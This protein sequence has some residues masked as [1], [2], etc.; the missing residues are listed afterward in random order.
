MNKP[1]LIREIWEQPTWHFW[2]DEQEYFIFVSTDDL[3]ESPRKIHLCKPKKQ[4]DVY[5]PEYLISKM[6]WQIKEHEDLKTGIE[7]LFLP[8]V[9]EYLASLDGGDSGFPVT[10]SDLEQYN[11]LVEN[12]FEYLNGEVIIK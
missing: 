8:E 3:K 11:W 1:T 5:V 12:S 6:D 4:D 2:H 7:E 10:G 9:N